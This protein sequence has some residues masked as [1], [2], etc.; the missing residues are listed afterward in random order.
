MALTVQKVFQYFQCQTELKSTWFQ[1]CDADFKYQDL[2]ISVCSISSTVSFTCC[3]LSIKSSNFGASKDY[4]K[5]VNDG[6]GNSGPRVATVTHK[7]KGRVQPRIQR[8]N[9]FCILHKKL[10]IFKIYGREM[11]KIIHTIRKS[12]CYY[13]GRRGMSIHTATYLCFKLSLLSFRLYRIKSKV[14]TE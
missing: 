3:N 13:G 11:T 2:N 4:G 6:T 9:K 10:T 12:C 14:A 8:E 1:L 5:W 7:A